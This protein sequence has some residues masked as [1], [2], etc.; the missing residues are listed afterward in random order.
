MNRILVINP[1]TSEVVTADMAQSVAGMNRNGTFKIECVTLRDGPAA[2][3]TQ[4]DVARAASAAARCIAAE[5]A[6]AYVVACYSDPGV[7]LARELSS[8]PVLGI[9]EASMMTAMTMGERFGI[10]AILPASVRRQQRH[11]RMLGFDARYAGSRD[12][13]VGVRDLATDPETLPRMITAG[14]WLRDE[15][16]ADVVI[17]GCAGMARHRSHIEQALGIPV[18][19]PSRAAVAMAL[20][21]AMASADAW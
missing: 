7:L 21:L 17:L 3:Q 4:A 16:Q 15:R 14:K 2:V 10:I 18:I 9:G 6:A 1:N 8:S 12:I 5:P 19:E 13:G 20:G 11:V